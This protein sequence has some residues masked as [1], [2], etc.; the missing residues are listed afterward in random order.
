MGT[1]G[2]PKDWLVKSKKLTF[3]ILLNETP[4]S[5]NLLDLNLV[6][7]AVF[8]SRF[9]WALMKHGFVSTGVQRGL[10]FWGNRHDHKQIFH[11]QVHHFQW[12]PV[13]STI[14]ALLYKIIDEPSL[15][16][17][18]Y[19]PLLGLRIPDRSL[20]WAFR[21]SVLAGIER[22]LF[23]RRRY[24][25]STKSRLAPTMEAVSTTWNKISALIHGVGILSNPQKKRSYERHGEVQVFWLKK[26]LIMLKN[27]VWLR[28]NKESSHCK[29]KVLLDL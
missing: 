6:F 1:S 13:A 5:Y 12:S 15:I 24:R 10:I 16:Y 18:R 14:L 7:T 3:I 20:A 29:K 23:L 27:L 2:S 22:P 11:C 26:Q 9:A 17:V 19:S 8:H 21:P 25:E 28:P 4:I